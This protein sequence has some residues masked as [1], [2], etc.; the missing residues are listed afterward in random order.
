MQKHWSKTLGDHLNKSLKQALDNQEL[1]EFICY[2]AMYIGEVQH[3]YN[4]GES[5][6]YEHTDS[7]LLVSID[8]ITR[9]DY[10]SLERDQSE[11]TVH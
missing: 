3:A 7:E 2:V 11:V 4:D 10:E 1:D 6:L 5:V 9:V 8:T